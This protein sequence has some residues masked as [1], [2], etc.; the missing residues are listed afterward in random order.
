MIN[1]LLTDSSTIPSLLGQGFVTDLFFPERGSSLSEGSDILFLFIFWV[2][3]FFFVV[4]MGLMVVFAIQY[5]RV[6]GKPIQPSASHNTVLELSWSIIPLLL[7]AV[8]FVWGW[9]EYIK[10]RVP[11]GDAEVLYVTAE[12]WKW[13][14]TYPNGAET[15]DFETI[16]DALAPVMALPNRPVKFVMNA[17]D[18]MHSFYV[19]AFRTKQDL[20][21]NRTTIAWADP[22]VVTHRMVPTGDGKY[23]P[24]AIDGHEGF[25]M[26]CTEY[27]GDQHSQMG[28]RFMIMEE[29]DYQRWL[30]AQADTSSIPLDEL[31]ALMWKKKGCNAC[32]SVDGSMNTGPTWQGLYG[33][34]RNFADGGS[35]VA[36]ENYIRESILDPAAHIVE[37]YPNQMASYQGRITE[38]EIQG[39]ITY[40][41]SITAGYEEEAAADTA[42]EIEERESAASDDSGSGEG[43]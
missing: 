21:P 15:N 27:C 26:F 43:S 41:K 31:G 34:T 22:N 12:K 38:R 23:V 30:A 35:A 5:R 18:V 40:M 24:E 28:G 20:F 29:E 14:V 10:H 19:P 3:V 25:Y 32:H 37:G 11:P 8:M 4:L 7:M 2:S 6:P 17:T 42:A 39:V 33:K 13:T 36:D 16:A 9:E 1:T